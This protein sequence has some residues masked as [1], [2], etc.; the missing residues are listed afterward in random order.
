MN[1]IDTCIKRPVF[2]T[3][4]SL[5]L[6]I[7]GL[8]SFKKIDIRG[9]PDIDFPIVSISANYLGADAKY[10]EKNIT[11][12]IEKSINNIKDIDFVTSSSS[13]G[14]S[15][16]TVTMKMNSD[17]DQAVN[18][19]RSRI[20][21][22]SDKFPNDMAIPTVSKQ[23]MDAWPTLWLAVSSDYYSQQELT[24]IVNVKLK[25]E[26]EKLAT[27]G[28]VMVVGDRKYTI[29]IKPDPL[30]LLKYKIN[31][32]DIE[33]LVKV[34]N[35]D[36][37][38]GK[39]DGKNKSYLLSMNSSLNKL[40]EFRNIIIKSNNNSLLRLKDIAS[41]ELT[42]PD[43]S[44]IIRFNSN[45]A[46]GIGLIRQASTN[47]LELSAEVQQEL[48]NILK[49]LP[50]NI[51]VI[52]AYDAAIPINAT[53]K[54]VYLTF[55][56][57]IFLVTLVVYLFL[58][59]FRTALIILT[60][61]PIS[62]IATFSVMYLFGFSINKFTLLAMILAIGLVVDD[63]IV[64]IENIIRYIEKGMSK[65]EA[66]F[67]A[68]NEIGFAIIAMTL[69]LAAVYLPI[70]FI[71]GFI[72][73][74]FV[75]FA[76]TL[77]FCVI[78][79]GIVALTLTPMLCSKFLNDT[80]KIKNFKFLENFQN[81]LNRIEKLYVTSL[82]IILNNK[83]KFAVLNLC[84]IILTFVLLNSTAKEFSPKEDDA[85]MQIVFSGPEFSSVEY[86]NYY[87]REAEKYLSNN[88]YLRGYFTI[89]GFRGGEN[90]GF[91]FVPL[92]FWQDRDKSQFDI[93]NDL[94]QDLVKLT[95]VSAFAI[96]PRSLE[97]GGAQKDIEFNIQT[98]KD[99]KNLKNFTDQFITAMQQ[100]NLFYN[101]E[102]D[103][104]ANIPTYYLDIDRNKLAFYNLDLKIVGANLNYA[105]NGKTISDFRLNN[106]IYDVFLRFSQ[107]ER[108]NIKDLNK[109]F[110]RNNIG[111]MV[112]IRNLV[113]TNLDASYKNY[114]HYNNN[115]SSTITAMLNK[116]SSIE[117]AIA[118]I[119]QF[120]DEILDKST[121][122]IEFLGE[123][124]RMNESNANMLLTFFFAIIF[125]YLVL[126]AQFESFKD[127]L[128]ILFAVPFSITGGVAALWLFNNSIN[129]YSNIGLVTLIG[130]VTKN[131]IMIIEFA[132][133]L[134]EQGEKYKKAILEASKLRLRPILMTSIATSL[135][136]LP[137]TLATGAGAGARN[138]IGLVIVGGVF[139]GTLFSLYV[140][141]VLFHSF[142][143]D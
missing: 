140:T 53:I 107:S 40:E 25:T 34:Q 142:K 106:Q 78:F 121:S 57:A 94:N 58:K 11:E 61:I 27:I 1:I 87:I 66:S 59:N 76:W 41:I 132:N 114:N 77:A 12:I 29:L 97:S 100:S 21:D 42:S 68:A 73:K 4:I 28:N 36:Y 74:L 19:I 69:T 81:L 134:K 86:N 54:S 31:A 65:L 88:P 13:T 126:A 133:Q 143:K 64:M 71:E 75:E 43:L 137:L 2:A 14:N 55:F 7:I 3:V 79:S 141:P 48:P 83:I 49:N 127:P 129:L 120:K 37:P 32:S 38:I 101:I 9:I 50:D 18:D 90:N 30:K 113:K 23:D 70:G 118:K 117:Q 80:K 119:E 109:V 95:G 136:A 108:N 22:I 35:Q 82:K 105:I 111:D 116:N 44:S 124:K 93:I 10:M 122:K 98:T 24:E 33:Q 52:T 92:K 128:L 39:L 62:L 67:K 139:I 123:I 130:L 112:A 96:P 17:I 60:T 63:A 45:N 6:I 138:S 125:I 110:L 99:F 84:F 135:G 46:L 56:E 103:L 102:T 26:F 115:N 131:S 8:I 104:K 91:A 47:I 89:S 16:I 5:M 85:F 51:Q 20:A 15:N 72:G